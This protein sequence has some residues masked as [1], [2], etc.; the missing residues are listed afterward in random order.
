ML[1]EDGKF[2]S[3]FVIRKSA[4]EACLVLSVDNNTVIEYLVRLAFLL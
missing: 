2:E 3:K 4:V 1:F